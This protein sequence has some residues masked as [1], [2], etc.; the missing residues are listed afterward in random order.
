MKICTR[1]TKTADCLEDLHDAINFLRQTFCGVRDVPFDDSALCGAQYIFWAIQDDLRELE[2]A[3]RTPGAPAFD[4]GH[5]R[6]DF[7]QDILS[8]L[9]EREQEAVANALCKHPVNGVDSVQQACG[10][11]DAPVSFR[12]PVNGLTA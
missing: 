9:T 7:I 10:E 1:S 6:H 11:V 2:S 3:M 8:R 12:G 5:S 4:H